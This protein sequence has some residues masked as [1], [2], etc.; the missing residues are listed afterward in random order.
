MSFDPSSSSGKRRHA[1]PSVTIVLLSLRQP[2]TTLQAAASL[3]CD[4]LITI[5]LCLFLKSQKGEMMK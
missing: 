1:L 4:L 5:Y 3:A 2:I